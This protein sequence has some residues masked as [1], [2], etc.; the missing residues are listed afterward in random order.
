MSVEVR[1]EKALRECDKARDYR[2]LQAV[3]R[4]SVFAICQEVCEQP[5]A[6]PLED[7]LSP[8]V[9]CPGASL[10]REYLNSL[11]KSDDI[12]AL[13]LQNAPTLLTTRKR[14]RESDLDPSVA[15]SAFVLFYGRGLPAKNLQCRWD[16]LNKERDILEKSAEYL[17]RSS[18]ERRKLQL[19]SV[20]S[21]FAEK[22][23]R[24]CFSAFWSKF[25]NIGCPPALHLHLLNRLPVDIMPHLT[26]PIIVTDYLTTCFSC[27]GLV[28]VLALKGMFLLM[29]DHGVEQPKFYEQLYSLLTPDAF[30]SR[31][32]YELFELVDL[33]LKSLRVPSYIAAAFAKRVV[34]IA[35][36][37]PAPTLYFSLPFLRQLLQRHPNCLSLIHR[38]SKIM[39]EE[40]GELGSQ[41]K[42]HAEDTVARLFDGVDPFSIEERNPWKSDAI[43]SSLWE[44]VLLEKHFLPAVPLMVSAFSSTAEDTTPLRFEK[45]YARLFTAEATREISKGRVPSTAYAVPEY[46]SNISSNVFIL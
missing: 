21:I 5:L 36:L 9:C 32:R 29:L 26:N 38:A 33:C 14:Q 22:A 23:H 11:E 2:A 3:F 19:D 43:Y 24:H 13:M 37:S 25:L 31:H 45:T 8:A 30:S 42:K 18:A 46:H 28:A 41:G 4:Q 17:N 27:G 40:D 6:R 35:L 15:T 34:Q 44:L 39:A 7:S 16:F 12:W 20:L 10:V 1:I